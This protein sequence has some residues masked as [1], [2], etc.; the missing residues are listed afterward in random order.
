MKCTKNWGS[1]SKET[2]QEAG[3]KEEMLLHELKIRDGGAAAVENQRDMLKE[4][5]GDIFYRALLGYMPQQQNLYDNFT[6]EEFL[7]YMAALKGLDKKKAG[8]RI[9]GLLETVILEYA[10]YK[11]IQT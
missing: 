2:G 3:I 4:K 9:N 6:G 8:I 11:K 10:R 5:P 1:L 7:W